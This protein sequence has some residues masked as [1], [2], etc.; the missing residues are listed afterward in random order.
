VVEEFLEGFETTIFAVCDGKNYILLPPCMDFKKAGENDTGP[1][2]GGMGSVCPV[3]WLDAKTQG[4]ILREAVEPTFE[5]LRR[6]NLLY[7]GILYFGLML[8]KKGPKILEYNVRFGDPETQA[9]LP[10]I[11]SD[12]GNLCDAILS[13]T[14]DSFPLAVSEKSSLGVVIAAEG[15]PGEYEKGIP[16][17]FAEQPEDRDIHVFHASTIRDSSGTLLTN[18]GRCF[19]VVGV[20]KDIFEAA[21]RVY[22]G[23]KN[24]SFKGAWYRPDIGKRFMTE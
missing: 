16:V 7:Q 23:V 22:A 14:L 5:G 8:T 13:G 19:T 24:V 3:P 10:V 18:G 9:L 1:N 12:F 15:Y 2:T 20:G 17:R 6:E 11:S 21:E 4:R